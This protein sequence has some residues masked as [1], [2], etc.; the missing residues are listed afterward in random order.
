VFCFGQF[1]QATAAGKTDIVIT[2]WSTNRDRHLGQA[3]IYD[4]TEV[5]VSRLFLKTPSSTRER[6]FLR[7]TKTAKQAI[8]VVSSIQLPMYIGTVRRKMSRSKPG[9]VFRQSIGKRNR[10]SRTLESP[11]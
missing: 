5:T 2:E 11:D 4:D 8:L 3:P 7:L 9:R 10:C 1:H 6:V